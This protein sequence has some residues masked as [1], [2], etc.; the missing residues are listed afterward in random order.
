MINSKNSK[1]LMITLVLSLILSYIYLSQYQKQHY[2]SILSFMSKYRESIILGILIILLLLYVNYSNIKTIAE[3]FIDFE[4]NILNSSDIKD[5]VTQIELEAVND[6]NEIGLQRLLT[7]NQDFSAT[8]NS[9]MFFFVNIHYESGDR[10][11]PRIY[12][13]TSH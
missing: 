7:I 12:S 11:N 5:T 10:G 4:Y 9:D 8:N 3:N 1:L 13:R 2:K 6:L